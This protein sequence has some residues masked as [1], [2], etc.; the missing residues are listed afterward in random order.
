MSV[1]RWE[2]YPDTAACDAEIEVERTGC[3]VGEDRR[4]HPDTHTPPE[5]EDEISEIVSVAIRG[6][7]MPEELL[8][9]PGMKE[10]LRECM[11]GYPWELP[12]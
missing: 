4:G 9:A 2:D 5:N 7:E 3:Y 11:Q 12:E 8:G 1:H 6:V 10:Y